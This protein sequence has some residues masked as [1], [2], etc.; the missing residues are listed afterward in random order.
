[1]STPTDLRYTK[2]HEWVR[3]DGD[4]VTVGIT[5]YAQSSLGDVVYV[6]MPDVDDAFEQGDDLAEIE[7]V[8]AVS[9]IYA[10]VSGSVT[11]TNENIEDSPEVVN[12]DPYGDGW[13]IKMILNDAA[14][15]DSLLDAAAYD[16]H[17]AAAG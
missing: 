6:D 2:S 9:N 13:L 3:V 14:E 4:I 12:E 8:K 17:T 5:A 7:S 15:L 1:M 10:P 16:A 11:E